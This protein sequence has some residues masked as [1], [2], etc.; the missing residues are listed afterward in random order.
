MAIAAALSAG[1][2]LATAGA[3]QAQRPANLGE[4]APVGQSGVQLYNFRDYLSGGTGEILC[5]A[6]PTPPTPYCVPTLPANNV[7]ARLERLFAFLQAQGIKNVELYGYPGNP[8]PSGS[9]PQGNRQGLLDLRA[10]GDK[11]GLRFPARHG[12]LSESTWDGEIAAAKILGQEMVGEG[13]TGGAGSLGNL[14]QTLA[15]AAQLNKLG[16]RSVE[17]GVGPAYFHNHNSEF[18][19]R[20][21]DSNGQLKSAWEIVMDN[22][23]PRYVVGQ[24]DIGWAVCGASGHATPSDPAVGA[25]YVNQMIQKFGRRVISF[26]V[27]DMAAGGIKPDCGDGDQRTIGKGVINFAPLF[28][29]AKGKTKYYFG[30]R[31][32]VGLG[33]A[34]NFNPFTNAAEGAAAMKADP[35][36]SLK[37]FPQLFSSVPKGTPAS[38]NQQPVKITNDGDAPL[39]IAGGANAIQIEADAADGGAATAADFAVVSENCR[40]KSLAPNASCTINVGFKPTR[41]NYTSVARLVIDSNSD[42]AVERVLLTGTQTPPKV[43]VFSGPSD[44]TIDAGVNAIKDLG[45]ANDFAVDT[46]SDASVFTAA[47]L[48]NYRA[49]VF[50]NNAGDRL[51]AAQETALQGYIQGG[52]GFVGIGSAA[53]AEPSNS[54]I[55]GLIGA[56]P[57][58]ASPTTASDQVVVFGDRVHPATKGLPLEWTRNDIYYRWT[59]RPT[60]TV[61]TLARHR[62]VGAAAGD[63]TTTGGTD[64]PISWCRD[65]QGGRSFYTGMG[66]TAAGYGQ[67]DLK[68]HLLGA[69][70]WAGGLVRGGCKAT[71]MSNY[72]TERLVSAAS[73][74]LTASGESHGVSLANN[75]WAIYIGRADCRTNAER[76]KMVGLASQAQI[77]DFAN[78]NV[79]V[80]CGTI[81][82]LDPKAVNGTVNSGVTQAA[83]LPVYG[84]RGGGNEVNGKIETGLL[85]VAAAP[86]FATTGHIYLQYV[87]TFN[88]DNPVHPGMADGDQRRITKM[89]QARIS[90]FTVNLN[91]KKIDLDSEVT[92]FNYDLQIWSC[93][94][95]GGGMAFDSEGNLYVTVGDDNS[96]QSTNGY[97]G[98]YQPQRCPTG[99]PTQATNTHCGANNVA[100]ND[101]RRT[102]GNTNDYNGKML[103]FNPIDNLADGSKPA[104]GVGTTYTL[105]TASS[106][107]GPNLFDGT[108]G[109]G[110]KAKPE[111]YAMGLRNPSRMTIDP[112]TDVPYAAWVGPDAG[113][114]SATQGPST[115]ET[116]TQL[117]TAGNYGWPYCMGNKQAYRDR[118]ADGSLR[119]TNTTG[120]V[121]GGP[122]SAPT[123]GWY[124]CNNLVNDSTNNTGLVTLPHVTGTGKDAGTAHSN[125]VWYSRG[126]PNNSN[127]CPQFPREQGA[128]NA[129]NYGS[130][131]P[132]QLCPYLTASGATVFTGP[133][134]RYK[135]G[136]DNSARWP[137]YW[138]GRWFL[139]DFGNNSAKHALLLD[140]ASDQDGS[141]PIYAD[142]FRGSLPWGANYMDS[143]FGPDGALYV[144]VYEG[145]F[146]TGSGAGLYRFKY[147]GGPDTPGPD[148]QWTST[149]TA[150]TVQF[151]AGASGGVAYEWDFGDGETAAGTNPLH[152]YAAPGAY[153]AKLTVVYADGERATQTLSVPVSDDTAAP[154]TTVQLNDATPAATYTAA[155]KVG[156][157]ANDGTGG[158]G[159]EWT[160]YRI[161]GGSWTRKDNTANAS[162]FVTEFTVGDEGY[163]TVEFRSRDKAGNVESPI[164][165]VTFAIDL[166]GGGNGGCSA[167]SDQFNGSALDPKWQIVN[168]LAGNPP[169]VGSGRLTMPMVQGDLYTNTGNAQALMQAVPSGSWVATAKVAH[170]TINADGRA[171]GLALINTLNPNYLLKTTVQYKTDTDPNTAGNQPGK[172]TERVLTANNASVVI[173]PATVPWPNSGALN[174]SGEF[175]W[176]RFVYDDAA[177]TITTW[178]STNGTTFNSFGAP[179]SVTQYLSQPGGLR[180]GVFTKHDAG[181]TDDIAQFD[182][183]NVVSSSDPQIP[184]DDCG[185]D[186]SCPQTDE[187]TGSTIDPKWSLVNPITGANP[188][189]AN[190]RLV[191]P[192]RQADLYAATGNAQLLLQQAPATGSW[193]ATAKVVHSGLTADGEALGLG[194]INSF[195]PNY[196]VKAT[197]QYKNDTD[198]NTSGNQPGKWAER[199]LTANGSAITLPPATVPY[200][201]SGALSTS[202]DYIWVRLAYDDV[203]KTLNTA[204]STD[205]V[206]FTTFGAPIS[207]TQYLNQ[208]GGYRIGVF[209]K[210]DGNSANKNVELESFTLE[211]AD[212]GGTGGD[213]TA[214]STTNVLD[215][216]TPN[217]DSGWYKGDVKVTLNAT[218]NNGGSGVDK[219]EYRTAGA[220]TWTAYTA[221]FTVSTA[222]TTTIEYRSTDKKGNVESTRTV[223]FKIDKTGPATSAKLNGSDPKATYTGDVAVDLDATDATSGVKATEI[224]VDGGDWKPYVEEETILNTEADL[225]KWAQAGPGKL[226]WNAADGGFFRPSGGLGM[227]WY[228]VKDYG[229]FVM[230]FQWR[231]SATGTNGNGGAF[232][233][234]PNPAEAVTRTAA[235]R[236]P[237]QVGSAQT[238]Q[239]WVAIYCGHEIQINDYQS[240]AQKTGSIY[241]FSPL[242]ATQAKVQP[243]GTWVDYEIKVV[244]QTYTISRNGE[245][246]QTFQNTPGKT[247]SR[248]GD[249][250]T[251]DRQFTRGYIGLQNHS[252]AD[253][254]DY[255]NVR[256]LS[257]DAGSVQGPVKVTGNGAH[258]VEYRSTDVAGNVEAT[259]KVDFTIGTADTVAP[260]TTSALTPASPGAGGTYN[261]PVSVQLSATDPAQAGGGGGAPKTVDANA[262]ADHWEPNALTATV[263]D[264]VRWNFPTATAGTVHDVWIIKPGESATSDGTR[265]SNNDTGNIVIPGGPPVTSVVDAAGTYTFMCKIHSHK[266][267]D[268]WEG[269][270]GKVTVTAGGGSTPGS[271]VDYTEYRVNTGG[272]TGEWVRKDNTSSASPFV[273]TVGVSAVGSHVVEYR[274]KDKAG[275]TEATKSVAFSIQ[276]PGAGDSEDADVNADVPL[277]MSLEF[278]GA[279]T[280]GPL[281]PGVAKDYTASLA[282]KVTSSSPTTALSAVD[283]STNAPG[284][285]VN[286]TTALPQPLQAAAGGAFAPIG[287]TP[288]VLK[289]WTGPLANDPVTVEFKQ[290]VAATDKLVAGHYSKRITFTLSATTP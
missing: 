262:F 274:S 190:G 248:S 196:F 239:A 52:G 105:P 66:R 89:A 72:S 137:K 11:Y 71:I 136:A 277:V 24:I 263:G 282:A 228:P 143:K 243:R 278:T 19:T 200:P 18:S 59:T 94:H 73:G 14:S 23:D 107:N 4:G 40:G 31:D 241:N 221:P 15:T 90:R 116:A 211:T 139:N 280:V 118:I 129:P 175:I 198:P 150:R 27:K 251:T 172:W 219:T 37:A 252:D 10:L 138:D 201:N 100:F 258:T 199:V 64:W 158:A 237:C 253:V 113:S 208:P 58:A 213:T 33:G 171:A 217:G 254:I 88:P 17:A 193:T 222:G 212:C 69:I 125:N 114:P 127:G 227:P 122:A 206:T 110:G 168:P 43:L 97:S 60:G 84:D 121:T 273:T 145:F 236:F 173:P 36:P 130:T 152:A 119:T 35:A 205:G 176:V 167:Q 32:P 279:A 103:R 162:P 21:N 209:G 148:L 289:S 47:N 170:A 235:N 29:S 231:D 265:L 223:T 204:T 5:P 244:G 16:K 115:Y 159:V 93:C 132:T 275:N 287:G 99:D 53:E 240:D 257:L 68:K 216:T 226:T 96:S 9:S 203:A 6:S 186:G 180:V 183:F 51:N 182:A 57:D 141:Q 197:V 13:G 160:E 164:G 225:A 26:H 288:T 163:H 50:L 233:R 42:D 181:G 155:V 111:I 135:E 220:S 8:F 290:P 269:M 120:Y 189:V 202:G 41:T 104:V 174:T 30:E 45:T 1:A 62:A 79:G 85:G 267:T 177:K 92:I 242:N 191:V 156:L 2:L 54:F 61:H 188:T 78:R 25:T 192:L 83:V 178:S 210:R 272:A 146:T 3:A 230:K 286:G 149:A 245:V 126:N 82:I 259:K 63:G 260:V 255:K 165:T 266:G 87:P 215:P 284:R 185:G 123:N 194:L 285:L 67:A 46:G 271:G 106:P 91:T 81:H 56:R 166:P 157:R 256:V 109:G 101:A 195:S 102:A 124:D 187:F 49:V 112:V 247:S 234:F 48:A 75:G 98:N 270:V 34:T 28:T 65:Y 238:D 207:T 128:N 108:E 246:L 131:S 80:G 142:S 76:G 74:D 144:Q 249:P 250:S 133:V 169:T 117:P 218:D 140:P 151:S 70:Q 22:T 39:V 214:P 20:F 38:A 232:V 77:L 184:G 276:A 95:Q 147:T 264:T 86:D 12:S 179:I 224:R 153:T 134:Y 161:D 154:T 229:D 55:T 44:A 7:N 283:Q 261:G 268:G 281:V